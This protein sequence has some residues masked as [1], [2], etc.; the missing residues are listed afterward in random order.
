MSTSAANDSKDR[1]ITRR[2]KDKDGNIIVKRYK[3]SKS[4]LN[5]KI[6]WKRVPFAILGGVIGL[7]TYVVNLYRTNA[8]GNVFNDA[9]TN[10]LTV[11]FDS[12]VGIT[13]LFLAGIV[14]VILGTFL[15]YSLITQG[16]HIKKYPTA[17]RQLA[18]IVGIF[19]LVSAIFSAFINE[20]G[21]I[22][23]QDNP[24]D[25]SGEF[26]VSQLSAPFYSELLN[27]LLDLLGGINNPNEVVA[28]VTPAGG[29]QFDKFNDAYL[30]KWVSAETYGS[31]KDPFDFVQGY[32]TYRAPYQFDDP[33]TYSSVLPGVNYKTMHVS[34]QI[35]S[36]SSTYSGPAVSPWNSVF[37]SQVDISNPTYRASNAS[38][39][40]TISNTDAY[41]SINGQTQIE[42]T[43]SDS[44]TIGY[45]DY[46]AN[47]IEEAKT[48]IAENSISY[49][50][51]ANQVSGHTIDPQLDPNRVGQ[52]S[53]AGTVSSIW[54]SESL[55]IYYDHPENNAY[56]DSATFFSKLDN[57]TSDAVSNNLS[58]YSTVLQINNEVQNALINTLLR[59]N[60]ES[61]TMNLTQSSVSDNE[62]Q[63]E[64]RAFYFWRR[65]TNNQ[66]F[67]VKDAIAGFVNL[68]RAMDIPARPVAGFLAGDVQP[69]QIT[70]KMGD[71]HMWVE[72]L[73]PWVDGNGQTHYSWGSF[74]PIP[75]FKYYT[76][77]NGALV[78][79]QNSLGGEPKIELEANS[80]SNA[81]FPSGTQSIGG[82]SSVTVGQLNQPFEMATRISYSNIT[83]SSQNIN[84]KLL[85]ESE[86]QSISSGGSILDA[87]T[88]LGI[89]TTS[90]DPGNWANFSITQ[91]TA[92][93]VTFTFDGQDQLVNGLT[94][95]TINLDA[96]GGASRNV[97]A[98]LAQSGLSYEFILVGWRLDGSIN[99]KV[100]N[101]E[102]VTVTD[103]GIFTNDTFDSTYSLIGEQLI[104]SANLTDGPNFQGNPIPNIDIELLLLN[105]T[106]FST[107]GDDLTSG[108][109]NPVDTYGL[110]VSN[111]TD[112]N[113]FTTFAYRLNS[114]DVSINASPASRY[115]VMVAYVP[116]SLIYQPLYIHVSDQISA[117]FTMTTDDGN[118]YV[119][120]TQTVSWFMDVN[121]IV[122]DTRLWA[123][124]GGSLTTRQAQGMDIQYMLVKK[125]PYESTIGN[126]ANFISLL[127]SCQTDLEISSASCYQMTEAG[128][129]NATLQFGIRNGSTTSTDMITELLI[130][131]NGIVPLGVYYWVIY[132]PAVQY[133]SYNASTK[134]WIST[135]A[136]T[137]TPAGTT[138]NQ[139]FLPDEPIHQQSHGVNL[140]DHVISQVDNI[141]DVLPVFFPLLFL[142]TIIVTMKSRQVIMERW[143]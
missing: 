105:P 109:F 107:L 86:I 99:F 58:V 29:G 44:P 142:S 28:N 93:T 51:L 35:Y 63:N 4:G 129:N 104:Y 102:T 77:E 91:S 114:S 20:N 95:D 31:T 43:L 30:W 61:N 131:N 36:T 121:T 50:D 125:S 21:I 7:Y 94:L 75:S 87:G 10:F 106:E 8:L 80:G 101:S 17:A 112:S 57:T 74:N 119:N 130:S 90:T 13:G 26:D 89:V 78:Y 12:F 96:T 98:I 143:L 69:D 47:W 34:Q 9:W 59:N 55:P 136:V 97:Y 118:Y 67:G 23:Q 25:V 70:I 133:F 32:E 92:G 11:Y 6:P 64:D 111:T 73:I 132:L 85:T 126:S 14:T 68:L 27:G 141:R 37:D 138:Q 41:D 140:F 16:Y 56:G 22:R 76:Q 2:I 135:L 139:I 115:Y 62:A 84:I 45:L 108:S 120:K 46:N 124:S 52:L 72:A 137:N 113:G 88:D 19:L 128:A 48:L 5:I 82:I 40:V 65:A 15:S 123:A 24:Q 103:G 79:G 53:D 1:Y 81:N 127:Q 116:G 83:A 39:P 33:S 117:N 66:L 42:S 71:I 122:N 60:Q 18:A 134:I 3:K 49:A 54:G 38:T 100:T 110:G